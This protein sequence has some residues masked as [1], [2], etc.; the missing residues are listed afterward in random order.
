M[1]FAAVVKPDRAEKQRPQHDQHGPVETA[2]GGGVDQRPGRK[3]SATAGDEPDLVAV[4]VR[5]HGVDNDAAFQVAAPDKGQQGAHA[6]V[7]AIHDGK[8][9]QQH[10][11][12]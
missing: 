12:Q 10:A 2:E 4:P 11:D 7:V 5:P 3:N 6:H 1:D 9:D 8:A